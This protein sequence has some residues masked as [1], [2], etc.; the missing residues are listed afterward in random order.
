M[1]NRHIRRPKHSQKSRQH[2][3]QLPKIVAQFVFN[4]RPPLVGSQEWPHHS[5]NHPENVAKREAER[6]EKRRQEQIANGLV[7][8]DAH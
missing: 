7:H 8:Q 5:P 4:L 3:Q 1:K 6:L 2:R